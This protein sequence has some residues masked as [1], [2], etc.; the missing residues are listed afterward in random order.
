MKRAAQ[1]KAR[2]DYSMLPLNKAEFTSCVTS[3]LYHGDYNLASKLFA[4][5]NGGED[6]RLCDLSLHK[7]EGLLSLLQ[8]RQQLLEE[9]SREELEEILQSHHDEVSKK[10]F[11]KIAEHLGMDACQ[12]WH[13]FV[14]VADGDH[15]KVAH[16]HEAVLSKETRLVW[17]DLWQQLVGRFGGIEDAMR[18]LER[19]NSQTAE[20]YVNKE[21]FFKWMEIWNIY[22]DDALE[23]FHLLQDAGANGL[24]ADG[25][26]SDFLAALKDLLL[27]AAPKTSLDDFWQRM[28]AEWPEV[29]EAARAAKSSASPGRLAELLLELLPMEMRFTKQGTPL[30]ALQNQPRISDAEQ[31]SQASQSPFSLLSLDLEAFTALAMH[32]DVSRENAAEL[33]ESI[34]RS[35]SAQSSHEETLDVDMEPQIFLDDFAEQ[36]VLWTEGVDRRR[37]VKDKIQLRFAP[38]RAALSALKAELLPKCE[39]EPI[40]E[41]KPKPTKL[42]KLPKGKPKRPQLPWC[43]YYHLRPNPMPTALT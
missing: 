42:P 9:W 17:R 21:V 10:R 8:V 41:P 16:L 5:L 38:V 4:S 19:N 26:A 28:A 36:I 6:V 11:M 13:L 23:Y 32:I 24:Q 1:G 39:A 2:K 7:P 25:L 29:L 31:A 30:I 27:S 37:P 3:F 34:A 12:A 20:C 15:V 18:M 40:E 22:E 14:L 43:T 35:T 33:F